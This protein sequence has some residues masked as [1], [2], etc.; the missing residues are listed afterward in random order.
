MI[1]GLT[2]NPNIMDNPNLNKLFLE[3]RRFSPEAP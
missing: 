3:E 2:D 1:I